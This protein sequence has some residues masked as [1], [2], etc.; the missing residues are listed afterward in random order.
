MKLSAKDY[1][2]LHVLLFVNTLG[3]VCSK[4]AARQADF[5]LQFFLFYGLMLL[6]LLGYAVFWQQVIKKMPLSTAYL[7]KPVSIFWGML[8]GALIFK[9]HITWRMLIGAAAV[10]AGIV[11]VVREDE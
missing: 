1:L 10:M 8:W 2:L 9:E 4:I 6:I 7:N 3:G 5:S 11:M